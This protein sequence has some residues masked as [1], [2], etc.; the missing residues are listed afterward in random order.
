MEEQQVQQQPKT[1]A[2]HGVGLAGLILGV[3]ALILAFIPCIGVIA[4]FPGVVALILSIVALMQ[5]N[6]GNG[7]KG[8][9]IAAL[10]ISILATSLAVVWGVVIGGAAR[11]SDH[12]TDRIE[13]FVEGV[14]KEA[15]RHLERSLKELGDELEKTFSGIEGFDPEIFELEGEITD[16]AFEKIITEYEAL[17]DELAGLVHHD[18]DDIAGSAILYSSVSVRAASLA[19]N[20][21]R[22]GPRLTEEQK[23]RFDEINKKY[24]RVM[25]EVE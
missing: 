6:K 2:G 22:V 14:D 3:I 13:R 25:D 21:I 10:V 15:I 5:A 16:E 12:W 23:A 24:E 19:A 20:L 18:E 9:I 7:A 4:L 17:V 1:N 8:L 11:N